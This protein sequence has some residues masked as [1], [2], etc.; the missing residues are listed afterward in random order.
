MNPVFGPSRPCSLP[1]GTRRSGPRFQ[2]SVDSPARTHRDTRDD[3]FEAANALRRA[4]PRGPAGRSREV[5]P[6]AGMRCFCCPPGQYRHGKLNVILG[7]AMVDC[8]PLPALLPAVRGYD[9]SAT[10]ERANLK[11]ATQGP[12]PAAP[13]RTRTALKQGTIFAGGMRMGWM[14]SLE[15]APL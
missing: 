3:A 1:A 7:R 14:M 5:S 6:E 11:G 4:I 10:Y 9:I 13:S 8:G 12:F 15:W 2:I